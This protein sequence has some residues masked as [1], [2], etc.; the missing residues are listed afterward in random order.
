[1]A[2]AGFAGMEQEQQDDHGYEKTYHQDGRLTHEK[3]NN[4]GHG[5]YTVVLGDRFVVAVKGSH[6]VNV[7]ALKA[8]LGGINLAG[9]E[10]LKTQGVKNG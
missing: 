7:D 5:E 8:A 10:A 3:W 6:V 9:L 4:D 2:L 1:M